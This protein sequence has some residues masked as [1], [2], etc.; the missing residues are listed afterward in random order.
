MILEQ[1]W[2]KAWRYLGGK[3]LI[4]WCVFGL[5]AGCA[6]HKHPAVP[7]AAPPPTAPW[8]ANQV[9]PKTHGGGVVVRHGPGKP[10]HRRFPGRV[11]RRKKHGHHAKSRILRS[12]RPHVRIS[13]PLAVL[14]PHRVGPVE[15]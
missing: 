13:H 8:H 1:Q 6:L 11:V 4:A 10:A 5:V 2:T 9:A 12:R 14:A 7:A 15:K 3:M